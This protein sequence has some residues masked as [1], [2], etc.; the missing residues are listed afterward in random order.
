MNLTEKQAL[1]ELGK[2][3]AHPILKLSQREHL[4]LIECYN[5]LEKLVKEKNDTST[6]KR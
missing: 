2:V 5:I 4:H 1:E 3:L 6:A